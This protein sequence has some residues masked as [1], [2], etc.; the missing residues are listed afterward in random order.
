MSYLINL[1][2]E[3]TP[4]H[5]HKTYEIIVYIRGT[6]L[7]HTEETDIPVSAVARRSWRAGREWSA[8]SWVQLRQTCQRRQQG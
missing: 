2:K 7:F 6:G 8:G 4:F 1:I 5:Q 3:E